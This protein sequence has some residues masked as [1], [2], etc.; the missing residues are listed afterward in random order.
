MLS[1][2][3]FHKMAIDAEKRLAEERALARHAKV[4]A[5]E[6]KAQLAQIK[7]STQALTSQFLWEEI[8]QLRERV[9]KLENERDARYR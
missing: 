4:K 7:A 2:I 9:A 3:I 8:G 5:A 6:A 1:S